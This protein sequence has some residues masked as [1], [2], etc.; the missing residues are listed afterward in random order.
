MAAPVPGLCALLGL[1]PAAVPALSPPDQGQD[2]GGGQLRA[3]ELSGRLPPRRPGGD[4]GP[5]VRLD[6]TGGEPAGAR[7]DAPGGGR[8]VG[9]GEAVSAAW[10]GTDAVSARDPTTAP[11]GARCLCRL[12]KQS[13]PGA[14]ACRRPGGVR[15]G[16]RREVR[17]RTGA[18][19]AGPPYALSRPPPGD[20]GRRVSRRY[21]VCGRRKAGQ[22]AGGGA[23][24]G[25]QGR[26]AAAVGL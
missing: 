1:C 25:A 26:A 3:G 19:S 24:G 20:P 16:G 22:A 6:G 7:D 2:R 9:G 21:A 5:T 23:G 14:V 4:T 17:D 13:L 10:G 18:G 11:G 15:A 12:S 8:S